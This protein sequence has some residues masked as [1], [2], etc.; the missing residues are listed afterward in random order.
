MGQVPHESRHPSLTDTPPDPLK[1]QNFAT[2]RGV[3]SGLA[4]SQSHLL[5]LVKPRF[6]V[7]NV[8][9]SESIHGAMLGGELTV[10]VGF[11]DGDDIGNA[12]G[13]DVGLV[14]VVGVAVG[15]TGAEVGELVGQT[16]HASGH[17]S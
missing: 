8:N 3:F 14:E 1:R 13:L 5:V 7:S 17:S 2:R 6:E 16:P 15:T 10:A 4:V 11:S 12:D 9:V